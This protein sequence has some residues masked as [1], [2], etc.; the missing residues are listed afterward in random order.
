MSIDRNAPDVKALGIPDGFRHWAGDPAEDRIGPFFW[1]QTAPGRV[2]SVFRVQP[3]HVNTY[4][5]VHGGVLMTFADY[6][7]CLAAIEQEGDTVVTVSATCDFVDAG[8]NGELLTGIGE[9]T[10]LTGSLAFTR[11]TLYAG[12]RVLM[13]ASGV[14]KRSARKSPPSTP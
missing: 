11:A 14:I 8:R 13:T 6:T 10:R 3:H 12:E 2:E 1:R 7:L 5:A 9:T 4:G